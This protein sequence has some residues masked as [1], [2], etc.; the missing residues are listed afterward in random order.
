MF[1]LPLFR[2]KQ[3]LHRDGQV[4]MRKLPV[5]HAQEL[6]DFTLQHNRLRN[7]KRIVQIDDDTWDVLYQETIEKFAEMV[8]MIP[9]SQAHH[10]A[11][12]G[13]LL[14]HTLEVIEHALTLR[15]Q[16]KLPLFADQ[17]K[18]EAERHVWTF[19]IFV[20]ALLHDAGKR[21]TMCRLIFP[22]NTILQPFDA[23]S[24]HSG[25]NYRIAFIDTKYYAL[26]ETLGATLMGWLLNPIALNY[27]LPRL[28]IMQEVLDYIHESEEQGIIGKIL[29]TAD[30]HSTGGSLAHSKTRRF[31]GAEL[32]NIGER[33]M[34]QLRQLLASNHFVINR[35]NGNVYTTGQG[36]TYIL[37][38]ILA[39]DLRE[40]LREQGQTDIPS[41]NL[42]IFDILQESGFAETN[43]D[44]QI[45]H[46]IERI[47]QGKKNV[48]SVIKFRTAKLFR[49]QPPE[50]G[51]TI[52]EVEG[53]ATKSPSE[54]VNHQ[55]PQLKQEAA[56]SLP[57]AEDKQTI[58]NETGDELFG[59]ATEENTW[60]SAIDVGDNINTGTVNQVIPLSA[61]EERIQI[62]MGEMISS[63]E[64]NTSTETTYQSA[65][66]E[67]K[68]TDPMAEMD[69]AKAFLDWF[70][71][72][73]RTRNIIINATGTLANKVVHQDSY[74][75][76]LVTPRIFSQ[77]ACDVLGLS[78]AQSKDKSIISKIQAPIHAKKLNI[79]AKKGQIHYYQLKHSETA[80]FNQRAKL[81][82]YL[83]DIDKIAGDNKDVKQIFDETEINKNLAKV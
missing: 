36:Y 4:D 12:P 8:Q 70:C 48:F 32:L 15:Q 52:R 69:I 18:Q 49:T 62:R 56:K 30:R 17:D 37:S 65:T 29:K 23:I 74:A 82:F 72:Q 80:A 71:D 63:D 7:I 3:Q 16:Y 38:K 68:Y 28:H 44:G 45:M 25:R 64:S 19:A 47:Y 39:D 66:D 59:A 51:G 57:N 40:S 42:R 73:I 1:K 55:K 5:M 50:F 27:L 43:T 81:F 78:E 34:T 22:D 77:F 75:V 9:A 31:A 13:G 20:A 2:K 53:K 60:E 24:K 10:H 35:S 26:H 33:L 76:A 21:I 14:I 67:Q 79:P 6:I 46:H 54:A 58:Y 61:T 11:V 83:F 41:D